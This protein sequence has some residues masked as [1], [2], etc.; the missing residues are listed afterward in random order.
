MLQLNNISVNLGRF[1]LNNI[2]LH[3][4]QG[5][6]LVILGPTGT[7]KTVLLETIAGLRRS[8]K[9]RI[10]IAG[11]DAT[12]T[13][14][15]MRNLGVVYQDYALFPHLTVFENIAFGLRFKKKSGIK[16]RQTVREMADFLGIESLLERRPLNLSGGERQ[17][18][19]LARALVLKPYA[20]LLDEPLSALDRQTRDRLR[21]ELKKIHRRTG[22]AI[23]HITHDLTEAFFLANHLIVMKDGSILQQGSP[24]EILRSPHDRMVAEMVGVHNF[25]TAKVQ[26][27]RVETALGPFNIPVS[28]FT[29]SKGKDQGYLIIPDWCVE[30]MPVK[31]NRFYGWQGNMR[32]TDLNFMD[33]QVELELTHSEGECLRTALSRRELTAMPEQI[34]SGEEIQVGILTDGVSWIR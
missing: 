3:I 8:D 28:S 26:K 13:P 6:Y 17:R 32:V 16:V 21:R 1:R 7:G 23:F 18:V 4:Q 30:P 15:E 22:V 25:L 19:A 24:D 10:Y 5:G 27:H 31:G 9:G 20:L 29:A 12:H 11:Q 14:P 2:S 34:R 33:G